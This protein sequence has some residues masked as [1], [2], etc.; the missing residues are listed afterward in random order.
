MKEKMLIWMTEMKD[1]YV[2]E[3]SCYKPQKSERRVLEQRAG[4]TENVK[5]IKGETEEV[6]RI[7][8]YHRKGGHI[9][10]YIG[11]GFGAVAA[12]AAIWVGSTFWGTDPDQPVKLP[13][14]LER[15]TEAYTTEEETSTEE[16]DMSLGSVIPSEKADTSVG[17]KIPM[18]DGKRL[19]IAAGEDT[20]V[21]LDN[22]GNITSRLEHARMECAYGMPYEENAWVFSADHPIAVVVLEKGK[23]VEE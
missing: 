17:M 10:M 23:E 6:K 13:A 15:T 12:A 11:M 4:E 1:E 3:A 21:A 7:N 2:L 8:N 14:T 22:E 9:M 20:L 18:E 5:E 19:L 16:T